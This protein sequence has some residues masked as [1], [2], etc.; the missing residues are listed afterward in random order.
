MNFLKE[1]IERKRKQLEE[2]NIL[3]NFIN[4]T[5]Y[6]ANETLVIFLLRKEAKRNISKEANSR[7]Y[8]L[9]PIW[10]SSRNLKG[11][12][13]KLLKKRKSIVQYE[14]SYFKLISN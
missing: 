1:E 10:K 6:T 2:A 12:T 7:K 3:V 9:T 13:K 11:Q 14:L 4:L 8:K 5:K